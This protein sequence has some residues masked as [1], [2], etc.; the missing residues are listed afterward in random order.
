MGHVFINNIF[1]FLLL[2]HS[3]KKTLN[4]K[5]IL[6]RDVKIKIVIIIVLK[7]YLRVDSKQGLSNEST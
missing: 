5:I 6:L 1:Y 3:C 2:E 4:Y 7:S